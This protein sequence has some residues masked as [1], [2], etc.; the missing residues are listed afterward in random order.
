MAA[1][2]RQGM[3]A[4]HVAR[5]STASDLYAQWL[6]STNIQ[7]HGVLRLETNTRLADHVVPRSEQYGVSQY[8]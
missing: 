4:A 3:R 1:S 7:M 5:N 8:M 2:L 6:S